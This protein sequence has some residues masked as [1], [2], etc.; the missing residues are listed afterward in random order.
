MANAVGS[1]SSLFRGMAIMQLV[2]ESTRGL[3]IAEIVELAGLAKPTV[4]RIAIQ[5]EEEGYLQ[6]GPDKR[7]ALGYKL[8]EFSVSILSN[9]AVGAPRHA[10]LETLAEEI[11]ETCN[12]TMLEGNHTVYFDRVEC[13]W[14]IKI[15]LHLGSHL[16]LH[17]TA[18]GK[19]FLA[20]M[21][22]KERNRLLEA[23]ALS[24]NTERTLVT[25]ELLEP[26]LK[27]IKKEGVSFDNEELLA[28]M[29][30]IA[31]PVFDKA[32]RICFT[33]AVH[34]PTTRRS[35]DDLKEF[36]PALQKAAEALASYYCHDEG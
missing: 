12:C 6:R 22:P 8:K 15:D 1:N 30:A 36:I 27:K 31:V 4:H 14:P 10:I 21:R 23:T 19:L 5:L 20:Y 32:N 18:S 24:K 7:F 34:A 26:E 25:S 28:G 13:N 29:V 35:V 17:A 2:A 16:P 3:S 33:V 9:V 11:G